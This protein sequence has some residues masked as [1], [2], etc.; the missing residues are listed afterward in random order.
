MINDCSFDKSWKIIISLST[1]FKFI[2]GINL[3]RNFGQH[4]A[5]MA[6]LNE[7]KGKNIITIDD[8]LQHSP[9]N[10]IDIYNQ[11]LNGFDVCYVNHL[12]R[13]HEK[14]KFFFSNMSN[15]I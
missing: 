15:I 7:C 11:L 12:D 13:K 8:D 4:N 10:I 3:S 5:I 9:N 14:C 1:N 6:G 2:K